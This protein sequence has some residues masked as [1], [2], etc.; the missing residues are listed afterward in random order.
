MSKNKTASNEA[1]GE[2][3]NTLANT[4]T[5]ALSARDE[6]GKP[7]AALLNVARQF[8]KDNGIESTAPPGS[9]LGDLAD[10]PVF[11]DEPDADLH[12]SRGQLQ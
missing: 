7:I 6:N 2:L 10:M 11:E 3:H 1:L 9:P 12:H 8:L 5:E 4:L